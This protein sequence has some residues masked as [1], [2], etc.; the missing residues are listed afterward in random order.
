MYRHDP[1]HE[2]TPLSDPSQRTCCSALT[3]ELSQRFGG[4]AEK[5]EEDGDKSKA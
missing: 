2:L 1:L 4:A 5:D 3:S